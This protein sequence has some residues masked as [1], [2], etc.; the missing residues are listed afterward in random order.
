[1][2]EKA[3]GDIVQAIQALKES[4]PEATAELRSLIVDLASSLVGCEHYCT[5]YALTHPFDRAQYQVDDVLAL[6]YH[7]FRGCHSRESPHKFLHVNIN[8]AASTSV[9]RFRLGPLNLPRLFIGLWQLSSPAWGSACSRKQDNA[10]IELVQSGLYAA[11]MADHYG[12]AELIFGSFRH[13]FV[14]ES[15]PRMVAATK[16]CVFRPLESGGTR[17]IVLAAV[18]ERCRRLNGRVE[19][20]QFHWYDYDDKQYLEVLRELVALTKTRPD[21][22]SSIGLCNFDAEHTQEACEYLLGKTGE[23]GVVSNQVQYSLIDSRPMWKMAGVCHKYNIKLLTYGSFCGGFLSDRWLN[24]PFPDVYSEALA[25]TP[26]QRKYFD[27]IMTWGNWNDLQKLLQTLR[28]IAD[29]HRVG[30]SSVAARW[31]LER[32]AVGAVIVGTRLGISSN[33]QDNL[34]IFSFSLTDEDLQKISCVAT[35]DKAR[36]VWNRVGDCGHEYRDMY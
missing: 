35:M 3:S 10:L 15:C 29:K 18:Q 25:L 30:I 11:D 23:V 13:R 5:S 4:R 6:L 21:L 14:G 36:S 33:V 28:V 17:G 26:S 9:E 20:L 16:W 22:V 19:L 24:K 32:P 2:F 34:K 27:M 1:M 7:D 8:D 31:V 12:D